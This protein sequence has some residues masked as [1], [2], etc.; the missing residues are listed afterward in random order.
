MLLL[1]LL[2]HI[3]LLLLLTAATTAIATANCC[4]YCYCLLL[5]LVFSFIFTPSSW[6]A[7]VDAQ[8]WDTRVRRCQATLECEYPVCAVAFSLDNTQVYSGGLEEVIRVWDLRKQQ[9]VMTLEGHS[10]AIT[11]M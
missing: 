3:F 4:H 7:H 9:V 1:L 5:L 2:L 6:F 8:L 11:G 10:D